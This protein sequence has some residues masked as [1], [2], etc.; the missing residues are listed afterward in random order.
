MNHKVIEEDETLRFFQGEK[1][2]GKGRFA[3]RIIG[4]AIAGKAGKVFDT[5]CVSGDVPDFGKCFQRL[6]VMV[7]A[8]GESICN[9][10]RQGKL[11]ADF[12][13]SVIELCEKVHGNPEYRKNQDGN[14]PYQLEIIFLRRVDKID[15]ECEADDEVESDQKIVI[16]RE[17]QTE[18]DVIGQLDED[19]QKR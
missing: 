15:D 12:S 4:R 6:F 2:V 16:W 11:L 14:Q 5:F 7:C 8:C 13:L 17:T 18:I 1:H 9:L 19:K 3:A 10:L